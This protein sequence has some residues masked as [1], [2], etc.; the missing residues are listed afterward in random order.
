MREGKKSVLR[1]T[2]YT[3][4]KKRVLSRGKYSNSS[5]LQNKYK[6]MIRFAQFF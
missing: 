1:F 4:F 3:Q 5:I 6:N 2:I